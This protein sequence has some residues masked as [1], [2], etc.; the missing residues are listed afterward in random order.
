MFDHAKQMRE[1][2]RR[3]VIKFQFFKE[4]MDKVTKASHP[5][6]IAPFQKFR[7]KQ[8]LKE[9]ET[10]HLELKEELQ[11]LNKQYDKLIEKHPNKT[12]KIT[13]ILD[14]IKEKDKENAKL[15]QR[16][17]RLQIL[18][19]ELDRV[20]GDETIST[21]LVQEHYKTTLEIV[22]QFQEEYPDI[23]REI[24]EEIDATPF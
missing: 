18:I 20:T 17:E 24:Q 11:D 10:R 7:V 2:I 14:S 15:L 4:Q 12:K 13:K 1:A 3:T 22:N 8:E 9:L 19:E 5:E 23:V 21:H 6:T 16:I